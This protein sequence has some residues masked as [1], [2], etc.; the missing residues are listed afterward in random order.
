MSLP[1][2]RHSAARRA[3]IHVWYP[4][5]CAKYP[6]SCAEYPITCAKYPMSCAKYPITCAKYPQI[7]ARYPITCAKVPHYLRH[8]PENLQQCSRYPKICADVCVIHN[9]GQLQCITFPVLPT[10]VG[11]VVARRSPV[12]GALV[13]GMDAL[14]P[15][16]RLDVC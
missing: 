12:H 3:A 13:L 4:M 15:S 10:V 1:R 8:V 6:A 2:Y 9:C 14:D 11:C 5:T 16:R 7:C